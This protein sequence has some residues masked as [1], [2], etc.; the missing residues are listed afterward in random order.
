[1]EGEASKYMTL[2]YS[3]VL[4][5]IYT[6]GGGGGGGLDVSLLTKCLFMGLQCCHVQTLSSWNILNMPLMPNSCAT[7]CFREFLYPP[8]LVNRS[9]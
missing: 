2:H 7:K 5:N 6:G 1:M 9:A 8:K 3:V 4:Y